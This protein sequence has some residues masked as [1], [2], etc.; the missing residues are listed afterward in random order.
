MWGEEFY[1]YIFRSIDL[2]SSMKVRIQMNFPSNFLVFMFIF[3]VDIDL[4]IY[5]INKTEN[6]S[7]ETLPFKLKEFKGVFRI[8]G[9]IG[10]FQRH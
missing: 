4:N 7:V 6:H 3:Q 1:S 2:F 9:D 8:L 5:Q 10:R